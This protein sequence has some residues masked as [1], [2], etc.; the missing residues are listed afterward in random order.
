M[1]LG[2]AVASPV[3]PTACCWV[4]SPTASTTRVAS[5]GVESGRY[6]GHKARVARRVLGAV[7]DEVALH[8][9]IENHRHWNSAARTA[10]E[11]QC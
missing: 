3:A 11:A 4:S 5:T 6:K 7:P 2:A 9:L 1:I 8:P 10:R